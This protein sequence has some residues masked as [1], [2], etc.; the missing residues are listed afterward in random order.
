M[1]YTIYTI[2]FIC[3]LHN[4]GFQKT[5]ITQQL[6]SLNFTAEQS[7]NNENASET[8]VKTVLQKIHHSLLMPIVSTEST[9]VINESPMTNIFPCKNKF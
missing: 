8:P 7:T 2:I 3:Y 6:S 5:L 1:F 9:D 4:H